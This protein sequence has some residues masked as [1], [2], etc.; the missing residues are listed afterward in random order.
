[1]SRGRKHAFAEA[2]RLILC[3]SDIALQVTRYSL[4]QAGFTLFNHV[5]VRENLLLSIL[6]FVVVK[7]RNPS[8][9]SAIHLGHKFVKLRLGNLTRLERHQLLGHYLRLIDWAEVVM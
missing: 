6:A 3:D 4:G 7:C 8:D 9:V 5:H 2:F 1:M